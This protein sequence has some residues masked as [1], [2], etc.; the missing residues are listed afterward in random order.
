MNACIL[1]LGTRSFRLA[2]VGLSDDRGLD[3]QGLESERVALDA[4]IDATGGIGRRT[5]GDA[6][7]T[8]GRLIETARRRAPLSPLFVIAPHALGEAHNADAFVE[9]ARR[10]FG[11][12]ISLV[13]Q[14]DSARLAYL[15]VR[16]AAKDLS[17]GAVVAYVDDSVL[18]IAYGSGPECAF[19]QTLSLGVQ[20]LHA[21]Y[22]A[23]GVGLRLAE[24][25]A[26]FGLVRLCAE[27]V[28]KR[29]PDAGHA[30]LLVAS[31]NAIAVRDVARA[32]GFLEDD[33][34]SLGRMAL[35]AL[36]PEILAAAPSSLCRLGIEPFRASVVGTTA[37]VLDA[38]ADLLGQRE[39]R[40]TTS[41]VRE[42]A[43]LELSLGIAV[44][45]S[46]S[47]APALATAAQA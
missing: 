1:E 46:A 38:L 26:L 3:V 39:V 24:A 31:E 28:A 7:Q 10:R 13:S 41:G 18:D 21:A 45:D 29:V 42:G 47:A 22:A 36:V 25:T 15:G 33:A 14:A 27:P 23:R 43:A 2:R 8:L 34:D 32:W 40:F 20:R 30:R 5:W 16:A 4:S 17:G 19:S 6:L 11:I 44:G 12:S 37:V 35:H 9:A